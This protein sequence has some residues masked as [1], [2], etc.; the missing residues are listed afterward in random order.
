MDIFGIWMC[1]L[2]TDLRPNATACAQTE[3]KKKKKISTVR[4]YV[5]CILVST[6]RHFKFCDRVFIQSTDFYDDIISSRYTWAGKWCVTLW[7]KLS[8]HRE[9]AAYPRS[10][11]KFRHFV[12]AVYLYKNHV[13][14]HPVVVA[15]SVN[16]VDGFTIIIAALLH[17]PVTLWMVYMLL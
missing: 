3:K 11:S 7:I 12:R 6:L 13:I 9:I 17:N 4:A 14:T 16:I 8:K 1:Y 15:Y 2:T 10:E 5:L